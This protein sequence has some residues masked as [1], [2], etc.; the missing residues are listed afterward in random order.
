MQLSAL[1]RRLAPALSSAMMAT[2]LAAGSLGISAPAAADGT[3]TLR[4]AYYKERSTRVIQPMMDAAFQVGDHGTATGHLLVDAI[5]C[6]LYTSDA[7][8]E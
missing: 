6:L 4:G 3:L 5:T 2:A 7:A 1:P 8:D